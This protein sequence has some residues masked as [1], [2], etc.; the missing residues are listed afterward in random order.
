MRHTRWKASVTVAMAVVA[1][2]ATLTIGQFDTRASLAGAASL[3]VSDPVLGTPLTGGIA[4]APDPDVVPLASGLTN[5]V[6]STSSLDSPKSAADPTGNNFAIP[7]WTAQDNG[8]ASWTST[9]DVAGGLV[10]PPFWAVPKEVRVI[11]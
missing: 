11:Q 8:G 3:S 1:A 2:V 9:G 4:D 5:A 10:N 7:E 6:F